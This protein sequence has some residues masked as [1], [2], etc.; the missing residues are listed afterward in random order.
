MLS[1]F[2]KLNT[3]LKSV[4]TYPTLEAQ[5]RRFSS[6]GWAHADVKN[7]WQI[8]S[9]DEWLS[10]EV[11]R[12]LD[13]I[14]PFDEWEEFALFAN[15]Y[16]VVTAKTDAPC[17]S[18]SSIESTAPVPKFQV[19]STPAYFNEYELPHGKRRFGATMTFKDD[20]G[21]SIAANTFGLG[22]NDR[23][24][25]YDIHSQSATPQ[26]IEKTH[27][28]PPSRV[29]HVITDLGSHGNLLSGGRASPANA[30]RDCWLF[31]KGSRSWTRL[32]DL[33]VPLYRHAVTRLGRSNMALLI[34][35]KTG[36][37]S[38]FEGCLLYRPGSGWVECKISG[39]TYRPTF[40][41]ALTSFDEVHVESND[42]LPNTD[43]RFSGI[44]SGGLL[45]D[46]T[47]PKQLLCWDLALP[48]DDV[49]PTITFEV[50]R[51]HVAADL[52]ENPSEVTNADI[53]VNRFGASVF[54]YNKD[55]I[56]M[57]G[58]II[59]GGILPK[60]YE[61]LVISVFQSEYTILAGYNLATPQES[62][63]I[64]R[65][66][67][68]GVSTF[69]AKDDSLAIMG[70]GATCFSMGTYWNKGCY[71]IPISLAHLGKGKARSYI[72]NA[73]WRFSQLVEVTEGPQA[74]LVSAIQG[75]KRHIAKV[76]IP[77]IRLSTKS[78]FLE[79]M[80]RGKPF[81]IEGNQPGSC[82]KAWKPGYLTRKVGH[83]RKVGIFCSYQSRLYHAARSDKNQ[84]TVHEATHSAMDFNTKNFAYVKISFGEFIQSVSQGSKMY[85]RSIS[86]DHPLDQPA[87][88]Q[89]D[90]P[91]LAADFQ[92]PEELSFVSENIFSSVLRI[93]GRVNMWLH[94]DV[95]NAVHRPIPQP[96]NRMPLTLV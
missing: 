73:P 54:P 57:I 75:D 47:M 96:A 71:S 72:L 92:L 37:S 2:E 8:W 56:V 60:E 32:E 9:D 62:S 64:P 15:H 78:S 12:K 35:G 87:N 30:F 10:P 36:S 33:P 7:L 14:E 80:K 38:M 76:E 58:G 86:E 61:I 91:Q 90:F 55:Y 66:L 5:C 29:C 39:S 48:A 83:E 68:V 95:R 13:R 16:C 20:W 53:L 59:H 45:E 46:N 27:P 77:R 51:A 50:L 84:V 94:Y 70:G 4:F 26:D 43:V 18:I 34:G 17:G 63:T 21:Q 28:G 74:E 81:I 93:S 6:L 79:V 44:L 1:H 69:M 52:H 11:R 82:I 85:L 40:G 42:K 41:A 89:A 65:P 49:R 88:L 19:V 31:E 25:S 22:A 24:R 67:L 3:P 23:K